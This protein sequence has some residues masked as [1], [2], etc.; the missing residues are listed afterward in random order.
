MRQLRQGRAVLPARDRSWEGSATVKR[1]GNGF[2]PKSSHLPWETAPHPG[3]NFGPVIVVGL[4]LALG[5][6]VLARQG[7]RVGGVRPA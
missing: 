3:A 7:D 1:L 2:S 6:G 4:V 5:F